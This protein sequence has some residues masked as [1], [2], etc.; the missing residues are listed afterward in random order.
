[1]TV[2]GNLLLVPRF[3]LW[4]AAAAV[5]A[6]YAC[7]AFFGGSSKSKT[8]PHRAWRLALGRAGLVALA[9]PWLGL[10]GANPCRGVDFN[11]GA[12][13]VLSRFGFCLLPSARSHRVS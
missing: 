9:F 3:G 13:Q 4:G 7:I 6:C 12:L 2:V 11:T 5:V 1:M 8:F 10:V